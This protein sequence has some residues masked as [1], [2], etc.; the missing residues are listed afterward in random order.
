MLE[1]FKLDDLAELA[2]SLPGPHAWAHGIDDIF[3]CQV[4]YVGF[5]FGDPVPAGPC[6][7]LDMP[8]GDVLLDRM[9]LAEFIARYGRAAAERRLAEAGLE[10]GPVF[11]K[12]GDFECQK[13]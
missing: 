12:P 5:E 6:E 1:G 11:D 8:A 3:V 2:E 13:T 9:P 4:C 10:L 7:P